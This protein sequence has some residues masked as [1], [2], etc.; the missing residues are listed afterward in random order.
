M[1]LDAEVLAQLKSMEPRGGAALDLDGRRRAVLER[2]N[3]SFADWA[4]AGSD[5][6]EIRDHQVPVEGGTILVR[7][8]H[9]FAD[10]SSL[11]AHVYAHGGGW[12]VG[13]IEDDFVD[14]EAR[15]RAVEA[16]CV[17]AT[18]EYR[19]APEHPFPIPVQ[20]VVAAVRWVRSA[21][22]ELGVDPDV[23]TLGGASAGA[24]IVCGAVVAAPDLAVRALLLEVPPVD[25]TWETA[26]AG[27]D[28]GGYEPSV[29]PMVRA[30]MNQFLALRAAYLPDPASYRDP[31]ASP[32]HAADLSVFPETHILTAEADLLRTEGELFGERLT[33]AGVS[34]TV[35]RY[36][37]ATHFASM[38]TKVWPTAKK[39]HDD[40]LAALVSVHT[41][42]G[43]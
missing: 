40:L 43:D 17:V 26:Q 8:Y 32:L 13:T 18:V 42:A 41:R 36:A 9:P 25:L 39:W 37:G 4:L 24:N 6:H 22:A 38:L 35:T 11:P 12:T 19:L 33:A 15:F 21:A 34:T 10:A 2:A 31:A 16:N 7:T 1:N 5:V 14:A 29:E 23:V 3:R 20:D 27:V 28:A 30:G